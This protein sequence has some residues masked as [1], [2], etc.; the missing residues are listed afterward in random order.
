MAQ[1]ILFVLYV[2][3]IGACLV[4]ARALRDRPVAQLLCLPPAQ[5]AIYALI[6][7]AYTLLAGDGGAWLGD[8][9]LVA[10]WAVLLI[11]P[12]WALRIAWRSRRGRSFW[13][14]DGQRWATVPAEMPHGRRVPVA[15]PVARLRRDEGRG[16]GN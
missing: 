1:T 6:R 14:V 5:F 7:R 16:A 12:L 8:W 9:P 10:F 3:V 2:A 15:R 13:G 4:L 11:W